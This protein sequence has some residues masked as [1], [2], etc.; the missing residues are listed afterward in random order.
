MGIGGMESP[1]SRGKGLAPAGRT[2]LTMS[3]TGAFVLTVL[4]GLLMTVSGS[5]EENVKPS[6]APARLSLPPNSVAGA[7]PSPLDVPLPAHAMVTPQNQQPSFHVE[8]SRKQAPLEKPQEVGSAEYLLPEDKKMN[9]V[10]PETANLNLPVDTQLMTKDT[11]ETIV[12]PAGTYRQLMIFPIDS[13]LMEE[14]THTR[15]SKSLTLATT[16]PKSR[17]AEPPTKPIWVRYES[18]EKI[19]IGDRERRGGLDIPSHGPK[20][21]GPRVWYAKS[22]TADLASS[23]FYFV[24]GGLG[25][26]VANLAGWSAGNI[27]EIPGNFEYRLVRK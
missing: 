27:R 22:E 19:K 10:P 2:D 18:L 6:N 4:W 26:G 8:S 1:T 5:A 25:Y 20:E 17:Y 16:E 15:D 23:A 12:L 24:F 9:V 7:K 13:S 14:H 21:L 11:G 3:R